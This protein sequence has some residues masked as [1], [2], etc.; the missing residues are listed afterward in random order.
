MAEYTS[1]GFY[2]SAKPLSAT[3]QKGF[4]SL[5]DND[6]GI[7]KV[8]I[9][10][11]EIAVEYHIY[12]YTDRQISELLTKKGFIIK[13]KKKPGFIKRQIEYLAKSN[14]KNYGNRKP[15]CC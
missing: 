4:K 10:E 6:R 14:Y 3:D 2:E 5:F 15:D 13:Q 1:I 9:S 7:E 8:A 11:E 12:L